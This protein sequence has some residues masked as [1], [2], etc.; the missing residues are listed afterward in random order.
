MLV[1]H[2]TVLAVNYLLRQVSFTSNN[3][4][5]MNCTSLTQVL[6]FSGWST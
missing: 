3:N 6:G 2:I 1:S 5:T 4:G